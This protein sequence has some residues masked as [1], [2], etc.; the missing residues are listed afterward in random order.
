MST[1]GRL[2]ACLPVLLHL[3]LVAGS[4]LGPRNKWELSDAPDT[5]KDNHGAL[6]DWASE[7]D[8]TSDTDKHQDGAEKID[9]AAQE[10][11]EGESRS[12]APASAR[13]P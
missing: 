2:L 9:D 4:G 7:D 8:S 3:A 12:I 5:K 6:S 11:G 10:G 1:K 13:V